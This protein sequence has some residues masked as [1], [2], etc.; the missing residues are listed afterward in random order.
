MFGRRLLEAAIFR[1]QITLFCSEVKI[2]SRPFPLFT[3]FQIFA[4]EIGHMGN[5]LDHKWTGDKMGRLVC[6]GTKK[7]LETLLL[8]SLSLGTL[9][10][11]RHYALHV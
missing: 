3:E 10:L 8:L 4:I 11:N 5:T 7:G 1:P 9:L 2:S 6:G